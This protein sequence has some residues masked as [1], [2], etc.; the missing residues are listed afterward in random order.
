VPGPCHAVIG[1]PAGQLFGECIA[2]R[3]RHQVVLAAVE[4]QDRK[5]EVTGVLERIEALPVGGDA[6]VD[7]PLHREGGEGRKPQLAG[8]EG[9]DRL[10]VE[11]RGVE[12]EAGDPICE[13]GVLHELGNDR[14][15]HRIADQEEAAGAVGEGVAGRS[16][17]IAPLSEAHVMQA[18]GARRGAEVPPVGDQQGRQAGAVQ[19]GRDAQSGLLIAVDAVY[20]D[21]PDVEA[22]GDQPGRH[23][24][25]FVADSHLGEGQTQGLAGIARVDVGVERHPHPRPQDVAAHRP[26][27]PGHRVGIRPH[28]FA[29]NRAAALPEEAVEARAQGVF[30]ARENHLPPRKPLHRHRGGPPRAVGNEHRGG[31]VPARRGSCGNQGHKQ[32]EASDD[33]PSPVAAEPGGSLSDSGSRA[34]AH[35]R[36]A[37]H[38]GPA[39]ALAMIAAGGP[40][41]ERRFLGF[42][43]WAAERADQTETAGAPWP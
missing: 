35:G 30:G 26:Q 12:Q 23:R 36:E 11:G 3:D 22:T 40:F 17:Q 19:G 21:R 43:D 41:C 15:T 4:E 38:P 7:R 8:I 1:D 10:P 16:P 5:V 34:G 27:P 24:S 39:P 25:Q 32:G 2:S 37:S 28:H 33:Q 6:G 9:E 14:P 18:V 29:E 13:G 31:E 20:D 42:D